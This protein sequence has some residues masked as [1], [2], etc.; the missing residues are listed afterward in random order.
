MTYVCVKD[1]SAYFLYEV[2]WYRVDNVLIEDVFFME[3]IK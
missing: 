3:E 1:W 2:R